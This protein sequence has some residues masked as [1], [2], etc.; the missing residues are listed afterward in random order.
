M[1]KLMIFSLYGD[2]P[3]P[4]RRLTFS[5]LYGGSAAYLEEKLAYWLVFVK[6]SVV[7]NYCTLPCS[8]Y[9]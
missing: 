4:C 3:V 7:Y 1:L 8:Y 9:V 6:T 5:V 2:A